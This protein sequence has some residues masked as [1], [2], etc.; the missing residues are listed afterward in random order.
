MRIKICGITRAEDARMAEKLGADFIGLVFARSSRR[1]VDVATARGI[2]REL[3]GASAV[4]VFV[5]QQLDEVEATA[6]EVGLRAVQLYRKPSR[7]PPGVLA[8]PAVRGLLP[9]ITRGIVLDVAGGAGIPVE[10]RTVRPAELRT[11][12]EAFLTSTSAEVL[13]IA[14]VDGARLPGDA[15][16]PMTRRIAAAFRRFRTRVLRK[17]GRA[18]V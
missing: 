12:R 2:V 3:A 15:P 14:T 7:R 11:A 5:E 6:R 4:G 17:T 1:R 18:A 16:G 10:E 9:G 13:P 8:T